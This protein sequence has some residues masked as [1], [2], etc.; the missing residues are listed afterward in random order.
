[1]FLQQE[2]VGILPNSIGPLLACLFSVSVGPMHASYAGRILLQNVG[3]CRIPFV[4]LRRPI[5]GI[6]WGWEKAI[7]MR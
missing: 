1:M 5:V 6:R 3:P 2:R 7:D 4:T